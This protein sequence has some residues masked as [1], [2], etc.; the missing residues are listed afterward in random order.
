MPWKLS[1]V[2]GIQQTQIMGIQALAE[3][4][5]NSTYHSSLKITPFTTLYEC[6]SP[7]LME[8]QPSPLLEG[9]M[10]EKEQMNWGLRDRLVKAQKMNFE[11]AKRKKRTFE[12]S[13][14]TLPKV[15]PYRQWSIVVEKWLELASKYESFRIEKK[16]RMVAYRLELP[17][18]S[19]IH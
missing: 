13:D 18:N 10:K 11:S 4:W 14:Q 9:W 8:Q 19:R 7:L 12:E 2:H 3:W 6:P 5:Y 15:Q 16:I 1:E 17:T